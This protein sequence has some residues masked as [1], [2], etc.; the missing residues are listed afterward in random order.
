MEASNDVDAIEAQTLQAAFERFGQ[1]L[2]ARVMRP[3]AGP[4]PLP[5]TL[6]RDDQSLRVRIER[7]GNHLLRRS[8]PIRI[9][10]VNQVHFELDRAPQ[11]SQ[12]GGLVR[13]RSPDA[14]ARNAHRS[15]AQPVDG[16]VA[17]D[18][19]RAGSR[20]CDRACGVHFVSSNMENSS[21]APS[22]AVKKPIA[23]IG[24]TRAAKMPIPFCGFGRTTSLA[25]WDRSR[26]ERPAER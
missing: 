12:R 8:R 16:Q 14:F 21:I 23:H 10:R 15:V 9:R 13:R 3:L 2:G 22:G 4:W 18:R 7:L 1:M 19:E 25:N 5:S 26:D 11:R 6:G 24:W 17:S 20:S